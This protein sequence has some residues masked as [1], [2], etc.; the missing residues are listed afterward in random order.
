ML[1]LTI[2]TFEELSKKE[3]YAILKLR[4]E[5][6]VVEQNCP[7]QEVDGKDIQALHAFAYMK[8]ELVAYARILKKGISYSDYISIGRVVVSLKQRGHG[9]GHELMNYALDKCSFYFPTQPI[10]ISAQA[11]LEKFYNQH[12]FESTGEAYLEDGIPH[13]GMLLKKG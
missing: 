8:E 4:T 6:F 11:H 7:Y 5:V 13:I 3:L 2:K 10:K 12:G 1:L 9:Y